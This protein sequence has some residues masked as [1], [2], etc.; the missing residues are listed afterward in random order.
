[1]APKVHDKRQPTSLFDPAILGPAFLA[2]FGKLNPL[3][4]WR[5]PV[6]FAIELMAL[7]V[8]ILFARDLAIGGNALFSGQIACWLRAAVLFAGF[9]EAV[10]EGRGKAQ[11]ASLRRA[12][13]ELTARR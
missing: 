12:R 7:Y 6:V 2:S 5:N 11:A 9:A 10:A 4:L 3:T 1:M 13:A 8:A